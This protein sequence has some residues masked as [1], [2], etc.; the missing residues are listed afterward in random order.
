MKNKVFAFLMFVLVFIVIPGI[1][2]AIEF[3]MGLIP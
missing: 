3:E 1:A 2:G